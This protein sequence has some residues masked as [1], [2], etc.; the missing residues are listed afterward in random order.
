MLVLYNLQL[1]ITIISSQAP[2]LNEL[3][4]SPIQFAVRHNYIESFAILKM[5]ASPHSSPMF[6]KKFRGYV[7]FIFL[8]DL[9]ERLV[10]LNIPTTKNP[11]YLYVNFHCI[12]GKRREK[13][14]FYNGY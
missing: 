8:N 11:F 13:A 4:A 3:N 9:L 10:M 6:S 12:I 5:L 2:D 14:K 1:D 7:N